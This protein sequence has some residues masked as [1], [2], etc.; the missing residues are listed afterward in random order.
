MLKKV[1]NVQCFWDLDGPGLLLGA[2]GKLV[3]QFGNKKVYSKFRLSKSD[4]REKKE[5]SQS[6]P[7]FYL[8]IG[9]INYWR[10]KEYWY[11]DDDNLKVDEIEALINSYDL[12]LKKKSSEAKTAASANR[13][14]DGSLRGVIPE[15]VRHKVWQRDAG[16]CRSCGAKTELQYDHLIPVSMGGANS[17]DNLQILCGPCNRRKG[18]SVV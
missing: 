15:D 2:K 17:V 11:S 4:V 1:N 16:M 18:A 8:R 10:F 13:V 7:E 6:R 14:P 9:S 3:L 12:Q 5:R